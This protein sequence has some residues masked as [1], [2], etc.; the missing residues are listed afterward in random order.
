MVPSTAVAV[1]AP[2]PAA[3]AYLH[4]NIFNATTNAPTPQPSTI[5]IGHPTV[6]HPA[7]CSIVAR[8]ALMVAVNGS[9]WITGCAT[10]GKLLD[11]KKT[12]DRTHIGII[13]RFA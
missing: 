10:A 12:P 3:P 9:A 13:T 11:E 6:P 5:T 1:A 2:V 7:P 4:R 8:S